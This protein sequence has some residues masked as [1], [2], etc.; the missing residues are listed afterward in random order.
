[1]ILR[2]LVLPIHSGGIENGSHHRTNQTLGRFRPFGPTLQQLD[3]EK[4]YKNQPETITEAKEA[5][6]LWDF[7]S[8]LIV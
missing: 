5:I 3:Y 2:G 7:V 6:I 1:M 8:K 4:W